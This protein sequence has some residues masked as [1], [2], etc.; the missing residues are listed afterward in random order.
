M[1]ILV[2]GANGTI[3]KAVVEELKPRHEIITAGRTSGDQKVDIGDP[4][5]IRALFEAPPVTY[6]LVRCSR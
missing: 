3:G 5:S 6:I 1:K 4:A 2:V